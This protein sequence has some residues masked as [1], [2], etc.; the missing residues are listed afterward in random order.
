MSHG[1]DLPLAAMLGPEKGS[2]V[3]DSSLLIGLV[4]CGLIV[5]AIFVIVWIVNRLR[6]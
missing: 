5:A 6:R 1:A 4:V 2:Q 3:D